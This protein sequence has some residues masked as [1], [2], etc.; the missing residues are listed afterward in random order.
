G[1]ARGSGGGPCQTEVFKPDF[2]LIVKSFLFESGHEESDEIVACLLSRLRI[3]VNAN[4]TAL[5]TMRARIVVFVGAFEG[6][7]EMRRTCKDAERYMHRVARRKLIEERLACNSS[8]IV[9]ILAA[10]EDP[11]RGINEISEIGARHMVI[12]PANW[13]QRHGCLDVRVRA[14]NGVADA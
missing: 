2:E 6:I 1:P 10:N 7:E 5:P 9:V 4:A 3:G 14:Q 11:D 12:E 13:V 8:T